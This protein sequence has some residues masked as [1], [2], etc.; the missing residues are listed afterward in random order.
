LLQWK[1]NKYYIS[2]VCVCVALVI[3][4][5]MRMRHIIICG[6]PRCTIFFK[7]SHKRHD[8][9]K[10]KLL[11]T[12]YVFW[13]PV[14]LCLKHILLYEEMSEIWS[15]MYNGLH[16]KFPLFLS[17]FNDTWIFLTVFR[18]MLKHKTSWWK[19]Y[20]SR[21]VCKQMDGRTDGRTDLMK[22]ILT[23]RNFAKSA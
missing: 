7:L 20:R 10:K 14:Q 12:K 13:C 21:V 15:K 5:A 11:S 22:L 4:N 17:D 9:R 16:V 23:F 3:H 8:F 6:L 18:K 19:S 1:S 2:W